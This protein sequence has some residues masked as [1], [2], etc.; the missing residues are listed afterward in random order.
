MSKGLDALKSLCFKLCSNC[1]YNHE[2]MLGDGCEECDNNIDI[3][4]T[5][6]KRL[7]EIDK[8]SHCAVNYDFE[9]LDKKITALSIKVNEKNN[10]IKALEIIK[11]KK[12]DMCKLQN[13]FDFKLE[14]EVAVAYYNQGFDITYCITEEE[15]DLLREVLENE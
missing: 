10:K 3:I 7:E 14:T 1:P 8:I 2:D 11:E 12:V 9:T 5:E 15:Y 6:L 4:T 13:C